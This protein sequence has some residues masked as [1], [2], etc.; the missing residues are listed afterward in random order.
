MEE[1]YNNSAKPFY[2]SKKWWMAILGVITPVLTKF[3]GIELSEQIQLAII[4]LIGVYIGGES[5][6]DSKK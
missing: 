2:R 4:T 1:N 5:W 6:I 3:T